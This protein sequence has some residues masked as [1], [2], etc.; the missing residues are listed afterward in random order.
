MEV[1][2]YIP[3]EGH[4]LVLLIRGGRVMTR[5]VSAR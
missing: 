1:G 4:I 2:A 3:G 5:R